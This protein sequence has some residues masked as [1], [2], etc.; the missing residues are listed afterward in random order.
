VRRE[1][2]TR[3]SMFV[4]GKTRV[5]GSMILIFPKWQESLYLLL[6]LGGERRCIEEKVVGEGNAAVGKVG[7]NVLSDAVQP[8]NTVGERRKKRRNYKGEGVQ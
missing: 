5:R 3:D 6:S 7:H 2:K 1:E 8:K 4:G